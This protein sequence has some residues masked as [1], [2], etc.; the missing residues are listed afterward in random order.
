[1]IDPAQPVTVTQTLAFATD[2]RWDDFLA[3]WCNSLTP[4]IGAWCN[5]SPPERVALVDAESITLT[6]AL[7]GTDAILLSW[8]PIDIVGAT[9]VR[10]YAAAPNAIGLNVAATLPATQTTFTVPAS[11]AGVYSFALLAHDATLSGVAHSSIV[12][13]TLAATPELFL[14]LMT[15]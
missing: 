11:T 12:T 1:M 10:L 2:G 13:V 14:P 6:A 8:T 5:Y 15:R 3:Q 9:K 4:T 7:S